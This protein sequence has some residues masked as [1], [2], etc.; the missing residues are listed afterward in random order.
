M[1]NIGVFLALSR[2]FNLDGILQISLAMLLTTTI[3]DPIHFFQGFA[4]GLFDTVSRG[5]LH[6]QNRCL[7]LSK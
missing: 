1:G 2:V 6:G 7:P 5:S 3:E 4:G